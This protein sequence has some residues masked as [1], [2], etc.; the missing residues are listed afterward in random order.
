MENKP[1]PLKTYNNRHGTMKK[2]SGTIKTNPEG[3]YGWFRWLQETNR[4]KCSFFVT[5]KHCI[6]IYIS[7]PSASSMSSPS[8][9]PCRFIIQDVFKLTEMSN[10]DVT[11][12]ANRRAGNSVLSF[13]QHHQRKNHHRPSEICMI[14]MKNLIVLCFAL[15]FEFLSEIR[16]ILLY[17]TQVFEPETNEL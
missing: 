14:L 15:K 5:H 4:R 9:T 12:I 11:D 10:Y 16:I 3:G 17:C 1:K 13:E 8:Y 7:P 6:I 2:Q